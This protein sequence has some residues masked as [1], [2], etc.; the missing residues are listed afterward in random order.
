MEFE[1]KEDIKIPYSRQ[2]LI[3]SIFMITVPLGTFYSVSELLNKRIDPS[4]ARFERDSAEK[5]AD[6]YAAFA[7]VGSIW[8]VMVVI[9]L[10]YAPQHLKEEYDLFKK[11]ADI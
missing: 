9:I 11:A 2:L 6:T 10:L 8:L 1:V 4:L 7:A 3:C 5:Q